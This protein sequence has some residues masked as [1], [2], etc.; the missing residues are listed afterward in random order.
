MYHSN[1]RHMKSV[2][3]ILMLYFFDWT[4]TGFSVSASVC[5]HE[6]SPCLY[7]AYDIVEWIIDSKQEV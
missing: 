5:N 1:S 3:T 6:W 2:V 7:R 4:T